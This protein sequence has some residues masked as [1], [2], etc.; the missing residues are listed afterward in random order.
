MGLDIAQRE[1]S[2][3]RLIELYHS[4]LLEHGVKEYSYQDCYDDFRSGLLIS[5]LVNVIAAANVDP[6]LIEAQLAAAEASGVEAE[7]QLSAAIDAH[8]VQEVLPA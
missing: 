7:D 8:N 4:L 6:A 2:D 1:A 5:L 3:G